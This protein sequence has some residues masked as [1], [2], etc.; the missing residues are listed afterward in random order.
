MPDV[1]P[2]TLLFDYQFRIP[3]CA[4]P[5]RRK[6]GRLLSLKKESRLPELC[7]ADGRSPFASMQAAWNEDGLGLIGSVRGRTARPTGN[8]HSPDASDGFEVWIDTRPA[9]NVRRATEY[10]H[11]LACLP[12]DEENDGAP[13]IISLP[14]PQQRDIRGEFQPQTA[15]L[16]GH[17]VK[18]GYDLEVW[19]PGS[20]LYGYAQTNELRQ[21]G[22]YSL[23]RDTTQ[24]EQPLT[25]SDEFP[26]VWDPS[27]WVRLE[28]TDA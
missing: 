15:Q 14:I 25:V 28:L 18:D 12:V 17:F 27:L 19:I 16:R 3:H 11:R 5:S 26:F 10:C 8:R 23:F 7:T 4:A 9:G 21:L 22:F 6:T 13:S 1:V 20:Q 24:G 2:A